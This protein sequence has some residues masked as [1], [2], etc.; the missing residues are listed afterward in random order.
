MRRRRLLALVG[1]GLTA[2]CAGFGTDS[3]DRDTP[4][5]LPVPTDTP[6]RQEFDAPPDNPVADSLR[7]CRGYCGTDGVVWW[8]FAAE[9]GAPTAV[10]PSAANGS[11]PEFDLTFTL[12]NESGRSLTFDPDNW[13]FSK[14]LNGEW[15]DVVG[16]AGSA[17]AATLAIGERYDWPLELRSRL[18]AS[19]SRDDGGEAIPVEGLGGGS[20]VFGVEGTFEGEGSLTVTFAAQ[21][22][23]SGQPVELE[24][25]DAVRSTRVD[26]DR[27]LAT[28]D[29]EGDA[30]EGNRPFV[31]RVEPVAQVPANATA[32]TLIPEQLARRFRIRDGIALLDRFRGETVEIRE[33]TRI[34]P[35]FPDGDRQYYRYRGQAYVVT[36]VEGG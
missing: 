36:L 13:R 6:T 4:T 2:G 23:V 11:L 5:P 3:E 10:Q 22:T 31:Y 34:V 7:P 14:F 24:P 27:L 12:G 1:S 19:P 29:R 32:R 26:G 30:S 25:T 17:D 28:V 33:Q 9:R 15:Y 8:D 35:S 16:G 20:Y 18:P 21:V